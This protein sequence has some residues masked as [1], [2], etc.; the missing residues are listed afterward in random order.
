MTEETKPPRKRTGNKPKQLTEGTYLGIPVG[1][2]KKIID[3]EEVYKLASIGMK[4]KEI[5]DWFQID[6]STLQYNFKRELQK[7]KLNL[8][9]S[10]RR[11]QINLALSGNAT[12]LIW[13]GKNILG[14]SESPFDS[15]DYKPL[16]WTDGFDETNTADLDDGT[17]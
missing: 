1:R 5:A 11:A 4:N 13:L 12:M 3:P 14:Q 10:L 7:G 8:H 17:E 2:D 16:P 9:Q 15:D 6:D